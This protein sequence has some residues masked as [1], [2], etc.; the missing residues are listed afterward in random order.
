M[1]ALVE[2]LLQSGDY[3]AVKLSE[4]NTPIGSNLLKRNGLFATLSTITPKGK[5]GVRFDV[6][7]YGEPKTYFSPEAFESNFLVKV[8]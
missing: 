5:Y 1:T 2:Q 7:Y 8:K 3:Q 6:D 4:N